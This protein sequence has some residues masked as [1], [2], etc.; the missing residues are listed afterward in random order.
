[1]KT[2]K[3]TRHQIVCVQELYLKFNT[4]LQYIR[5]RMYVILLFFFVWNL[6]VSFVLIL[7]YLIDNYSQFVNFFAFKGVHLHVQRRKASRLINYTM[8]LNLNDWSDSHST[9]FLYYS[10]Y[11]ESVHSIITWFNEDK[12]ACFLCA[13]KSSWVFLIATGLFD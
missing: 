5:N 9:T 10:E 2:P 3:T 4:S 11:N 8:S 12:S 1:M 7:L 6:S 13:N